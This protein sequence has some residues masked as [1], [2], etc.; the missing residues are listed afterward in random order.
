MTKFAVYNTSGVL[1]ASDEARSLSFVGKYGINLRNSDGAG[2]YNSDIIS[3]TYGAKI[4]AVQ[5]PYPIGLG[6][7]GG[8]NS[9]G[10]YDATQGLRLYA[11]GPG[12]GSF[13]ATFFVFDN[14][15]TT[16][17]GGPR[18]VVYDTNGVVTFNS[19]DLKLR[20]AQVIESSMNLNT[21]FGGSGQNWGIVQ[22]LGTGLPAGNYAVQTSPPINYISW[23]RNNQ[24]GVTTTVRYVVTACISGTTLQIG[25][26]EDYR[27]QTSGIG[28]QALP[29]DVETRTLLSTIFDVSG[30]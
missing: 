22:Q 6:Y 10:S 8:W 20:I 3:S 25:G 13:D 29:Y 7:G 18:L 26:A 23:A 27:A 5:S 15:T 21:L 9:G 14:P 11:L 28:G 1:V 24:T 12:A 2:R 17:A 30:L 19:A 16:N 4:I